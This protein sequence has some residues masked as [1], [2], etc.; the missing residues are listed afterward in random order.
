M[1]YAIEFKPSADKA[2]RRLPETAQRRI[3]RAV[4]GLV[5]NPRHRGAKKLAGEEDLWRIRVG[6]FRVVYEIHDDQLVVL[7]VRVGHRKDIYGGD[8]S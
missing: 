6:D 5:D 1:R 3:V 4:D 7:V 2:L 8:G